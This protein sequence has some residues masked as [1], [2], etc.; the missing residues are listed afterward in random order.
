MIVK[1]KPIEISAQSLW[2][3]VLNSLTFAVKLFD[4]GWRTQ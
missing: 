2:V 3:C 1:Y 4:F